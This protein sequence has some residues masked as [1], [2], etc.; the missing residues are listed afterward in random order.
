MTSNASNALLKWPEPTPAKETGALTGRLV[1][2]DA[3]R[4]I[5]EFDAGRGLQEV[6]ARVLQDMAPGGQPWAVGQSVLLVLER[7]DASLPVII[8]RVADTLPRPSLE[9]RGDELNFEGR[10]QVVLRCGE[11][12]ITLR[13]DG[14]VL[15]K[16]SRL[17]SRAS[18]SNKIRGATVLIN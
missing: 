1:A 18:E 7:G 15:I 9:L 11:A 4:P 8:G 14:Q 16:G 5:V 12:S 17:L 10:E 6:P 13:A 3:G 2:I